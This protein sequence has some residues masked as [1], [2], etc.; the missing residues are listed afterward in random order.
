MAQKKTYK[1][2][3]ELLKTTGMTFKAI[4]HK[5]GMEDYTLYRLRQR[6]SKMDSVDIVKIA[7][8]TGIDERKISDITLFFARKVDKLQQN[9]AS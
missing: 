5:A 8:A 7:T 4:A 6:P 2:L 1:P 9:K 3:D